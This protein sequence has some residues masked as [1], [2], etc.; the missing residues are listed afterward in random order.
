MSSGVGHSVVSD[1]DETDL[2]ILQLL[3][4]DAR[5]PYSEIAEVVDQSS[6]IFSGLSDDAEILALSI[7]ELGI[8]LFNQ[9]VDVSQNRSCRSS[10]LV[11]YGR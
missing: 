1:L 2:E 9:H 3:M 7:A 5:R 10:N 4:A 6:D 11:G 8:T